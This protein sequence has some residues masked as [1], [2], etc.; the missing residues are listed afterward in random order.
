[1]GID[2]A[3]TPPTHLLTVLGK[4]FGLQQISVT[5]KYEISGI[6]VISLTNLI[7]LKDN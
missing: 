4:K 6:S 5:G 3:P 7:L 1:L 2:S